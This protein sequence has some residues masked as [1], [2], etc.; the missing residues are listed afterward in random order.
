M[1]QRL[2]RLLD[3]SEIRANMAR[4]ARGIDR[5]DLDLLRSCY[6]D[7]AWDDH[8][9]YIGPVDGYIDVLRAS[10]PRLQLSSHIMVNQVID[11]ESDDVARVETYCWDVLRQP[12]QDGGRGQDRFMM[13]RYCDRFERRNGEWKVAHRVV[14]FDGENV[15]PVEELA[16]PPM[17]RGRRDAD[18]PALRAEL[19]RRT[20]T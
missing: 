7:D 18:D 17:V 16:A 3:E 1:D 8:G 15:A 9:G 19:P 14:V 11:F 13:L 10:L 6:H 5:M 20:P 2:Q 12:P 4:Y